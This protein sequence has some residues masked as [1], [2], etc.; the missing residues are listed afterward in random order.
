MEIR[1]KIKKD[2]GENG[3]NEMERRERGCFPVG[4]PPRAQLL[5]K[6]GGQEIHTF[7][8]INALG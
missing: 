8:L 4:Y 5:N 1:K 2:S 3:A 6:L 7:A